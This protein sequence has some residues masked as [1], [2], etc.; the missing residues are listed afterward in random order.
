MVTFIPFL[1]IG[2][3]TKKYNT[4][5]SLGYYVF[6]SSSVYIENKKC[7]PCCLSIQFRFYAYDMNIATRV[8]TEMPLFVATCDLQTGFSIGS[9]IEVGHRNGGH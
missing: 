1:K 6:F 3:T 4:F 2:H 5:L 7:I 8:Q 9:L